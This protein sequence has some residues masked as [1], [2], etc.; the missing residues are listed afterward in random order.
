MLTYA[1]S[2]RRIDAS[3]SI[4]HVKEAELLLDT[5]VAGRKDAFNPAELLLAALCACIIKGIERVVPLISFDL[6]GVEVS[7]VAERQDAPPK[8]V[9]ITYDLAVR[10]SE[11]GQRLELLH[12]NVKKYGT[13][14]NT[15]AAATDITGTIRRLG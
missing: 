5:G 14:F 15:L 8:I 7:V 9:R 12:T 4:A 1:V 2:A 11:S 10:T 13:I 6:D 3:G